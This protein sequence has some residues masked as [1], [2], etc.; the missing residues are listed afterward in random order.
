MRIEHVAMYVVDLE[1][2]RHF[3]E[4]YL[5]GTSNEIYHNRTTDFA[6]ILFLLTM[7]QGLK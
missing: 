6:H 4:K 5:G 1:K 7:A 2:A 3:F